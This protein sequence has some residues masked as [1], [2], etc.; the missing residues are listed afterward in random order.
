MGLPSKL[1]Q[2]NAL[3][4]AAA[5][6]EPDRAAAPYVLRC[7][8]LDEDRLLTSGEEQ[9]LTLTLRRLGAVFDRRGDILIV[10]SPGLNRSSLIAGLLLRRGTGFGPE[11]VIKTLR[12]KLGPAAMTNSAFLARMRRPAKL[13]RAKLP[14]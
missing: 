5:E 9:I 10:C 11:G 1:R 12:N 3:V 4:Y 13:L 14:P 6:V 2:V 7:P 8:L